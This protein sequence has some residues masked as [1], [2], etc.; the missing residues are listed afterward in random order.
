MKVKA[1]FPARKFGFYGGRRI[2]GGEVFSLEKE[3]DFSKNWME[4]VEKPKGKPGPKP[5]E[6]SAPE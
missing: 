1:T 3:K 6:E 5:K 2:Y 4:W